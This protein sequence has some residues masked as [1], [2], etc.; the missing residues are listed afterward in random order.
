MRKAFTLIELLVVVAIIS[1]LVGVLLPA[2]SSARKTGRSTVCLANL[3]SIGQAS[4]AYSVS[5]RELVVPSYNMTGTT[6]AGVPLDGWA[7]IFDRDGHVDASLGQTGVSNPFYCPETLNIAGV[8]S[9]QTGTDLENPKGWLDWPFV[10]TGTSN[11]AQTIPERGFHKIIRVS[12]WVNADN[13]IGSTASVTPDIYYTASVGYGPSS[14]GR[15]IQPMMTSKIARASNLVTF[16]D[17]L[18]A[19]RQRDNRLGMTNSRIGYRHQGRVATANTAFADGHA[20]P[21]EGDRFPRA[22][23]GSNVPAQVKAENSGD[24]PTIYANPEKTLAGI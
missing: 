12:Y 7:P 1:I 20:A 8:S 16:A 22:L 21:I 13:P 17:G 23:G 11:E 10:R 15:I 19:G 3:R 24:R 18:Y 14:E 5:N 9:G 4:V 2:L 6:G